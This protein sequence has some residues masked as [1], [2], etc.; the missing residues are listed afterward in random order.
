MHQI[1]RTIFGVALLSVCTT[2]LSAQTV[3]LP[4]C[5]GLEHRQFDFWVGYWDVYPTGKPTLVA[6][7]LI[8]RLYAGCTI[9]ENWM[10]VKGAGGGSLN[11]YDPGDKR[12]HQT[13]HD[14]QNSRV[15]F[16]GGLAGAKMVLLGFWAGVNGPG[17]DGLTR[18]SY[19][20]NADGSVRQFGEVS[21]DHGLTWSPNFDFTYKPSKDAPPK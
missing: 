14:S 20:P 8:E 13:W 7:S 17:Q 16:D 5:T 1:A 2:A 6:H 21:T 12:W 18:M 15:E 10:P 3:P 9:R 19:T 4:A 11:M